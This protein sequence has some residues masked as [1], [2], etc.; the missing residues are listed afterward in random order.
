MLIRATIVL[1]AVLNLGVLAWWLWR[2]APVQPVIEQPVGV[3]RLV[4]LEEI[5]SPA[6]PSEP[7]PRNVPSAPAEAEAVPRAPAAAAAPQSDGAR[8]A[9]SAGVEPQQEAPRDRQAAPADEDLPLAGAPRCEGA[10]DGPARGWR[11]YL[12][13]AAD[14]AAAEATARAIGE[15]G[16]SDYLVVRD[17]DSANGIALGMYSTEAAAQRRSSALRDKG[18]AARCARIPG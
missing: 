16:F 1:L 14:L 3:P 11:V 13:P 15:A 4:L 12:P 6:T 9:A 2:P 10:D 7:A 18:F 8:G 5:E 17:G